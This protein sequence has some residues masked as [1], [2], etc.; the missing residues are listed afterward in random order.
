MPGEEK[1]EQNKKPE[2]QTIKKE[3]AKGKEDKGGAPLTEADI[4]LFKRYGKGPYA[5]PIKKAED[6]IRDFNQKI[7][8]LCGIKESDTGLALPA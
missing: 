6:D 7:S 5:E 8:A 4:A 3:D 2:T 1:A